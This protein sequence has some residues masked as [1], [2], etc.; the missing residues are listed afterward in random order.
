MFL[1]IEQY[2]YS[3]SSFLD[4]G[5]QVIIHDHSEPPLS[6]ENAIRIPP[7]TVAF[8]SIS[9]YVMVDETKRRCKSTVYWQLTYA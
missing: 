2:K 9:K 3:V 8:I 6:S 4:A 1:N 5:A 7:G